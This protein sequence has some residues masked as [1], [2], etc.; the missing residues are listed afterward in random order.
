MRLQNVLFQCAAALMLSLIISSQALAQ[1]GERFTFD[2]IPVD[3]ARQYYVAVGGGY[4]GMLAFMDFEEL[5]KVN[6]SL[7]IPGFDGQLYFNGGGGVISLLIVPNVRMGVFGLGGS[8]IVTGDVGGFKRSVR[9]SSSLTGAQFDYAIRLLRSVTVLPGVMIGAGNYNLE[10]TQSQPNGVSF[11]TLFSNNQQGNISSRISTGHFFFYP[12]VNIE[13]AITQ[14][15]MIRA[16]V[17]YHGTA[18]EGLWTDGNDMT[19]S[20]VPAINAN[21][22]RLQFGAFIGLF[23]NQ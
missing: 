18:A 12:A 1:G 4:L 19:V 23:Q 11:D 7:G 8:R 10:M 14:F 22:L 13:W 6:T 20:N 5:N 3:D 16:G 17:G 2:D 15:V 9:F 21:G